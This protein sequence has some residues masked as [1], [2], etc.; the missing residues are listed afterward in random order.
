[1]KGPNPV[2]GPKARLEARPEDHSSSRHPFAPP[3]VAWPLFGLRPLRW[4][5]FFQ[6]LPPSYPLAP[7]FFLDWQ[8]QVEGVGQVGG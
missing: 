1:M 5:A 7:F 2:L 6:L 3:W 4:G 8:V